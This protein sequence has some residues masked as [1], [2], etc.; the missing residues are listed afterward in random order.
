MTGDGSGSEKP[1]G[2]A[3]PPVRDPGTELD[4][5]VEPEQAVPT[6]PTVVPVPKAVAQRK[7]P[8]KGFRGVMS[9]ALVLQSITVLLGLPVASADHRLAA[10]ELGIILG[11]A[12]ACIGCC[13]LVKRPWIVVAIIAIQV[14]AVGS[15]LIYPALGIMGAIFALVWFMLLRFRAEFRRRREAGLLPDQ[16]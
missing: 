3:P 15:W 12:V 9:G 8:E 5:A 10:W 14:V 13:A 6:E 7:D 4:E 16:Q 11:L 2:A 1:A